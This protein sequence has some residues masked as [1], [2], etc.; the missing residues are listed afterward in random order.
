VGAWDGNP[1]KNWISYKT[2]LGEAL[3]GRTPEEKILLPNGS[4]C[5]IKEISALPED[6]VK[7]LAEG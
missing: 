6:I 3:L 2:R 5:V 7:Y 1:E 4:S